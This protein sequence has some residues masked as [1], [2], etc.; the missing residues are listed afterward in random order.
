ML[1]MMLLEDQEVVVD[2]EKPVNDVLEQWQFRSLQEAE[3]V[4]TFAA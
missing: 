1:E 2:Q 3:V 4:V